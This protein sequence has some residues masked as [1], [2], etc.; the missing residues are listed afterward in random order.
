MYLSFDSYIFSIT[1][2]YFFCTSAR[3][4]FSVGVSSPSFTEKSRGR[5]VHFWIRLA[6]LVQQRWSRL[7]SSIARWIAAMA[8]S[9]AMAPEIVVTCPSLFRSRAAPAS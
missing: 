3:L 1:V 6:L 4:V 5:I 8:V 7:V 9:S 2:A